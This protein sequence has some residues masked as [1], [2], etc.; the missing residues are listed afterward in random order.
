[1]GR[2]ML[3]LLLLIVE[4]ISVRSILGNIK[5][6]ECVHAEAWNLLV[7]ARLS[8]QLIIS[9]GRSESK[10]IWLGSQFFE[11]LFPLLDKI[12]PSRLVNFLLQWIPSLKQVTS[13]TWHRYFRFLNEW[14]ENIDYLEK[15]LIVSATKGDNL[16]IFLFH[17]ASQSYKW[18]QFRLCCQWWS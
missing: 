8:N 12:H 15:T 3:F 16:V 18:H 10:D 14:Q 2:V 11:G 9:A 7:I 17:K 13:M 5:W 4:Q 1:M 6:E